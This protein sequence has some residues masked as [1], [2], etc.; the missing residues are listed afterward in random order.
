MASERARARV[1]VE[2]LRA[3]RKVCAAAT[4]GWTGLGVE[5]DGEGDGGGERFSGE[6]E[7]SAGGASRGGREEKERR[8][9]G[10]LRQP[11]QTAMA[12]LVCIRSLLDEAGRS[13][14]RGRCSSGG[15]SVASDIPRSLCDGLEESEKTPKIQPG[16]WK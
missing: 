2:A 16:A 3:S 10:G 5:V 13:A 9:K 1:R 4:D 14:S 6:G 8:A 15:A 7:E 12:L 11:R